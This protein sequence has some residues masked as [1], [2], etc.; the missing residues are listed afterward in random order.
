MISHFSEDTER[1]RERS[2]SEWKPMDAY[3]KCFQMQALDLLWNLLISLWF[4]VSSSVE[5][6]WWQC[7]YHVESVRI[8]WDN[9]CTELKLTHCLI[10]MSY[11]YNVLFSF[12][13]D[14]YLNLG[15]FPWEQ[16]QDLT[17]PEHWGSLLS[18]GWVISLLFCNILWIS[19]FGLFFFSPNVFLDPDWQALI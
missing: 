18:L 5:W 6:S 7:P 8:Q 12:W 9:S 3:Y 14:C 4:L 13:K 17:V 2:E 19:N 11:Y 1:E 15:V 10:N 16:K